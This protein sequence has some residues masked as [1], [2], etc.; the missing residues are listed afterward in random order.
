VVILEHTRILKFPTDN[1]VPL[2]ELERKVAIAL[3]P[4]GV[5]YKSSSVTYRS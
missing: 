4:L 1:A 5:V 3:D 2:V